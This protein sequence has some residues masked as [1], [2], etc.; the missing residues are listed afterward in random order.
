MIIGGYSTLNVFDSTGDFIPPQLTL[1]QAAST[2]LA[3]QQSTGDVFLSFAGD[4]VIY[5]QLTLADATVQAPSG[6]TARAAVLNAHVDPAGGGDITHC[7]FEYTSDFEFGQNFDTQAGPWST[8]HQRE[9][10]ADSPPALPYSSPTDVSL[11]LEGLAPGSGYHVR[12]RVENANGPNTSA[13]SRFETVGS[14]GFASDIGSPG[15]GDG[16]LEG[17]EDVALNVSSGDLYVADTGNSRVVEFDANGDFVAAWG[18]GVGGGADFEVCT[19]GCQAGL[20]GSGRGEF[21]APAF[22]EVDNSTGPSEGDVYVGDTGRGDVQKFD[23]SGA[24]L[25]SWGERGSIDFNGDGPIEGITVDNSG[26]LFVGSTVLPP[27]SVETHWTEVGPDGVYRQRISTMVFSKY[28]FYGEPD[29]HGID[30]DSFGSLYQASLGGGVNVAPGGDTIES[31]EPP[32]VGNP[33]G[34]A[35]DRPTGDLYVSHRGFIYQFLTS[36]GCFPGS[37]ISSPKCNPADTFG[38]GELNGAM[39]LAFDYSSRTLYAANS[40][41]GD[42]ADFRTSPGAGGHHPAEHPDRTWRGDGERPHRCV[43]G[44]RHI[45]ML[46]RIRRGSQLRSRVLR[47]LRTAD[48]DLRSGGRNREVGGPPAVHLISLPAGGGPRRWCRASESR[49]RTH[50]HS[51]PEQSTGHRCDLLLRGW[52]DLRHGHRLDQSQ[53]RLHNLR[54]PVRN[55]LELRSQHPAKRIDRRRQR[56]SH[57]LGRPHRPQPGDHISLPSR[58]HKFQRYDDGSGS[59]ICHGGRRRVDRE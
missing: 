27:V 44:G 43:P 45:G 58:G 37:P 40:G 13:E 1:S 42:I 50:L 39:G 34:L 29:G 15:S 7:V 35:V 10:D 5:K 33:T 48:P 55:Q 53:P 3:L 30:I 41:A 26:S 11:H 28:G 46:F 56:R 32:T 4:V 2:G 54:R 31:S 25:E 38:G 36:E 51:Q 59:D 18:W 19:I 9:C 20:E 49:S 12:V 14:Y 47:S 17:P 24:L 16:Q 6:V 57:G 21:E 52:T 23:P 8:A 22:I